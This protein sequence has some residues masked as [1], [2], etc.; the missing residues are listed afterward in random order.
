MFRVVFPPIIRSTYNWFYR[1]WHLSNR[2]C[3]LPLSWSW[4]WFTRLA[5]S[6]RSYIG[7][8]LCRFGNSFECISEHSLQFV[9]KQ[10]VYVWLNMEARS[11]SHCCRGDVI[12]ITRYECYI[13]AMRMRHI[14]IYQTFLHYLI[15]GKVFQKKKKKN[16]WNKFCVLFLCTTF[17]WNI[18]HSKKN[19]ARYDQNFML[20]FT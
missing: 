4:N 14:V 7:F 1:I 8:I 11:H 16:Y 10:A 5:L 3:C 6:V 12:S 17:V 20:V 13:H 19:W 18:S 9:T 15:I 2:I